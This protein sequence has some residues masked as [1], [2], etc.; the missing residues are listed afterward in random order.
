MKGTI[1]A[2]IV[3]ALLG[4]VLIA[5]FI[6]GE[7]FA[8]NASTNYTRNVGVVIGTRHGTYLAHCH[9]YRIIQSSGGTK[10]N[11]GAFTFGGCLKPE[12]L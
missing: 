6:W 10:G 4:L 9:N 5:G 7:Q 11:S 1:F 3:G 8:A 2:C 12:K